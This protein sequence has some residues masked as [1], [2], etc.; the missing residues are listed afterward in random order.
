MD[1]SEYPQNK[2]LDSAPEVNN[3]PGAT[4]SV[5][6]KDTSQAPSIADGRKDG[7]DVSDTEIKTDDLFPPDPE[8]P[9]NEHKL[10]L[11]I[12]KPYGWSGSSYDDYDVITVH[13]IRDNYRTA[14]IDSKGQW[15]LKNQLFQRLSTREINY[16]YEI[17]QD[18]TLYQTDG[19]HVLAKTLID[20]YAEERKKLEETEK[21]RPIIWVCHDLGGTIV[22]QALFIAAQNPAKYG[23][24]FMHTT[25]MV[26]MGTPHRFKS[27]DDA[28]DQ[29]HKL[30]LL[31]GPEIK[32]RL[33]AKIRHLV[34]Q[35]NRVN[36]RFL[37]TKLYDRACIYNYFA[38]NI[39]ASLAES[40]T[41]A[42][43][44]HVSGIGTESVQSDKVVTPFPRY[45]HFVGHSFEACGRWRSNIL[46]HLDLVR[47][48]ASPNLDEISLWLGSALKVSYGLINLHT[49][50][51][52]L[53]PPTRTLNIPFDP[54]VP[55]P[56]VLT[57]LYAQEPYVSFKK[58]KQGPSYLHLH[59]S[60]SPLVNISEVSRLFYADYDASNTGTQAS[61]DGSPGNSVVYFEFDQNDSRYRSI[62]SLL[63]YLINTMLW[64][65]WSDSETLAYKEL[66]YLSDANAWTVKDLYQIFLSLRVRLTFTV[67]LTFFISCFDQCQEAERRWFMDRILHEQTYSEASCR[68]IISTSSSDG[69][70]IDRT[71]QGRRVNLLDFP[72][73]MQSS[74]DLKDEVMSNLN[75]LV[76][77][78]PLYGG[79]RSQIQDLLQGFHEV[80]GLGKIILTWLEFSHRGSSR[81]EVEA[82][83][84]KL[85]PITVESVTNAITSSLTPSLK[86]KAETAI[87]WIRHAA[88]PW[89]PDALVEALKVHMSLDDEPCLE[90]LDK[91]AEITELEKAL[92]GIFTVDNH[93]VKFSH[94]SFY[95]LA[96]SNGGE[97]SIAR[98]N[99]S[100]ATACLRYFQFEGVQEALDTFCSARVP[101][102]S[103]DT[104]LETVVVFHPRISMAEY[105]VRFWPQHYL[106]SG[107]FEPKHLVNALF[108]N[109]QARA[110]WEVTFWF[111]SNPFT[112]SDRH[113]ISTLPTFAMLGLEDCVDEKVMAEEGQPWFNSDCWDA[114]IEAIRSNSKKIAR[115]LLDLVTVDVKKLQRAM[116]CAA[117]QDNSELLD[118]LLAKIPDPEAFPWPNDFM[119]RAVAMGQ[120]TVLAAM[121]KAG[122]DINRNGTYWE[123]CAAINAALRDQI[124]ALA[125]LLNSENKPD[126]SMKDCTG[127]DLLM[128]AVR[129]GDPEVVKLVID[130]G[131]DIN[132]DTGD[133][134]NGLMLSAIKR[135]AHKVAD[136]LLENGVQFTDREK[137]GETELVWAARYGL[138][139]CARV[140]LRHQERMDLKS[141][142]GK[143]LHSAVANGH[144]SVVR[145]F[146]EHD[147]KPSLD[148]TPPGEETLLIRAICTGN[149]D[150]VSLLIEHGAKVDY[151]DPE[152]DFAKT[153]VSRACM[154]GNL[155]IVKLLLK[156]KADVNYTGGESDSPMFISLYYNEM[157]V[158]RYLLGNTDA[159]LTWKASD[160]MGMLHGC[161]NHH[162]VLSNLLRRGVP[163]DGTSIWGTVLHMAARE[164]YWD[165]INVLLNNHPKPDLEAVMGENAANAHEIGY[166]PLQLA[167]VKGSFD[168]IKLLLEA[169]ANPHIKNT[170]HEDLVDILLRVE[171]GS[172][173]CEKALK[174]L[175]SSPYSLPVN[176]TSDDGR[177]RLHVIHEKTS[178]NV[179]RLLTESA[180]DLNA[181]DKEGDTPL[182][183]A[184]SKNNKDVAKHLIEKGAKVSVFDPKYGS[185]LHLAVSKGDL[186]LVKLLLESGAD[187]E[188]V[189]LDYGES[190]VYTALGIEDPTS[191]NKI[192]RYLVEEAKV[193]VD[194]L[195]GKLGYPI[196]RAA[197][198]TKTA[199]EVGSRMLKFL[200][201]HKARL[202]VTDSQ[203]R[204]A[205][206][207]VC[208]STSPDCIKALIQAGEDMLGRDKIGRMPIHFAAANPDPGCLHY[209]LDKCNDSGAEFVNTKDNDEWTPLMW[210]ARS[211]SIATI[212]KLL[213]QNAECWARS[214][215]NKWSALKLANFAGRPPSFTEELV[216]KK[217][218]RAKPDGG[219]EDWDDSFHRVKT[220]DKK[221]INI[222]GLCW[223]CIE[224]KDG[225]SLCFKCF[226]HRSDFHNP[227]HNFKDI[228]PLYQEDESEAES[229]EGPDKQEETSGDEQEPNSQDTIEIDLDEVDLED[230]DLDLDDKTE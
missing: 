116:H 120:E 6:E 225:F 139:E 195:G 110:S 96:G 57:W 153:P 88:E 34:M 158:A 151:I 182:T 82:V 87:D 119:H 221:D 26:F 48:V 36:Q 5:Q 51:H 77:A 67:D 9:F 85:S 194:K 47:D 103:L 50:L 10:G 140:L 188:M 114:I 49:R 62:S 211:G 16:S 22:K 65:F 3:S 28:E 173:D 25:G 191:L 111:L 32:E 66:T 200:I 202:S 155:D 166:T 108:V 58:Q 17:E 197:H 179:M 220:G 181:R 226:V 204:L 227:E 183:V 212:H 90:D 219:E 104:P 126:L 107:Q 54:V 113:Y 141:T 216:P 43:S 122:A 18:S 8:E 20:K 159:D 55:L 13:G 112:R 134:E 174:L 15:I 79:F 168:C 132:S 70:G 86:V 78:R 74:D 73:L 125:L 81:S 106:A 53:A 97:E 41:N 89:S 75:S 60:G 35:A 102:S 117:A 118:S 224:C 161:Y 27:Q 164:G 138:L 196:V 229:V 198:V 31:P 171:P 98:I 137:K 178:V 148:V 217:R 124:S 218:S 201:R 160:G 208:A 4:S 210:A 180:S 186:D 149:I 93:N 14:W 192:M 189:D 68:I 223:K 170:D 21:D 147:H 145:L 162:D 228:G 205:A 172:E 44:V 91:E 105:A 146:L 24:I 123:A 131:A 72:L 45:A 156:S 222:V 38:Q 109:R 157:D 33:F 177:T 230:F 175:F 209:I 136:L 19:I 37:T 193:P 2:S 165:S 199:P 203:G 29:L 184:V 80:P 42:N 1:D 163:I 100:I 185:I 23:K 40:T 63:T 150:L 127:S 144:I 167:C 135:S 213:S 7:Q 52:S 69:L 99:S 115:K 190:L 133:P 71:I 95:R 39:K 130:A 142:S 215:D 129:V 59:G 84:N 143:P 154:E 46:N 12:N 30:L 176:S 56:P 207:L 121:L 187:P 61:T 11:D 76:A 169:G 92:C 214:I 206:H 101:A 152:G 128:V 83:I 64:H 94:P